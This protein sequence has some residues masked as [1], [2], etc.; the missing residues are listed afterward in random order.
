[1]SASRLEFAETIARKAGQLAVDL[2]QHPDG[3]VIDTKGPQDFVT[4]ADLA[5][6]TLIRAA[7]AA[8]YPDDAV[9]GEEGGL[10][11][12]AAACWIIDPI[13][14]T[15]NYMRG[16]PDWAISVGYFDGSELT[17]GVIFA[18]DLGALASARNGQ[19]ALL[20]GAQ[21]SVSDR[22][23]LDQSMVVLGYSRRVGLNDHLDRIGRLLESGC[24]YR[25]Q[26][27]ATIGLM[28]VATGRV[29]AYY[30]PSLNVWDAA[31]GLMI[32]RAAGGKFAA[33]AFPDFLNAPGEVMAANR[34]MDSLAALCRN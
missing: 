24:E 6:E 28:S 1:M 23:D 19:P 7:I 5:V 18:P 17:H 21:I 22:F 32:V 14:G 34:N 29:E 13:D 27:A 20:N 26:G 25:R 2:R 3:L 16:L 9:L 4:A 33:P 11:G 15:A 12:D 10:T 31:A 8:K 30:E